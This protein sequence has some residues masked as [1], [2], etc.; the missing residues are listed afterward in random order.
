VPTTSFEDLVREM[1]DA[2]YT[3]ARKDS[4]VKIA[5]FKTFDHHE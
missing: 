2:D 1:I 4:L 5:G 3:A